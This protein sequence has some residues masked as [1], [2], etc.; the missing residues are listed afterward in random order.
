MLEKDWMGRES[1][2]QGGKRN[3]FRISVRTPEGRNLRGRPTSII[4]KIYIK[5]I[6]LWYRAGT[7]RIL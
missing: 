2:T 7:S 6:D 1:G 5:E 3:T 4:L